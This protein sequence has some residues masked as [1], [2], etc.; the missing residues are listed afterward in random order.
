[1]YSKSN[2]AE[3]AECVAPLDADLAECVKPLDQVERR[4]VCRY[5]DQV[6]QEASAG[7]VVRSVGYPVPFV[8]D[9]RRER[10]EARRALA[11]VVSAGQPHV[12]AVQAAPVDVAA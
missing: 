2:P 6:V 8:D 1:M 7:P 9:I 4:A 5:W 12:L 3:L 11:R 10:R